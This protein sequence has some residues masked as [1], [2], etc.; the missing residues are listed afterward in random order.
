MGE[1]KIGV[2]EQT[3]YMS[4]FEIYGN[5]QVRVYTEDSNMNNAY[6]LRLTN[7]QYSIYNGPD[8]LGKESRK[9]V[10]SDKISLL[11]QEPFLAIYNEINLVSKHIVI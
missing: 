6:L 9:R 5:L 3:T 2:D 1:V 11:L 8:Y 7:I 4:S 10:V